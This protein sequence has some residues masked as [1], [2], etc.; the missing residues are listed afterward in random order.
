[1]AWT[2]TFC[3]E[4]EIQAKEGANVSASV[5]EA[6]HNNWIAEIQSYVNTLCRYN[7]TDE[8]SSLNADVQGILNMIASCYCAIQG[9]S[10]DMSGYTSRIE[11]ENMINILMYQMNRALDL[12]KD[13]KAVTYMDGA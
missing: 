3:T 7:F 12:I 8:Y 5:T 10:Y 4:A 11:A 1:M 6:M 2:G 9:I 13:Q